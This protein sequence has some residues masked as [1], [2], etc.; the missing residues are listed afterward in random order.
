[1]KLSDVFLGA[2]ERIEARENNYACTAIQ[3]FC[4]KNIPGRGEANETEKRATEAFAALFKP[5][6]TAER[7]GWFSPLTLHAEPT[8]AQK[9]HRLTALCLM[10]AIAESEGD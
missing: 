5:K 7:D 3:D 9:E 10:A 4:L 1:M 8:Q 2:A 6:G